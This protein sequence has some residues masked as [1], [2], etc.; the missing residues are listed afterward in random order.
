MVSL[1]IP[2]ATCAYS[3]STGQGASDKIRKVAVLI[4]SARIP[5]NGAGIGAWLKPVISDSLA[6]V[7]HTVEVLSPTTPPLP[8]GPIVDGT[9]LPAGI[10]DPALYPS[11]TIRKW[12]AY[13]SSTDLLV[14]LTPEYNS[15][16]PGE[17]KNALDH[18]YWEWRDKPAIIASYGSAGGPRAAEMLR[19]IVG[20][21]LRMRLTEKSLEIKLPKEYTG[22]AQKVPL[23]APFPEFLDSY[24]T[25]V[26]E[27]IDEVKK[28]WA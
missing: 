11:E 22:G 27:A 8:V 2:R 6:S 28:W 16:F 13:V 1:A 7:P 26:H 18:R 25:D 4:A 10:K 17:L 15:G 9:Y 23:V 5:C 3:T 21:S 12:S 19:G 24:Q 14:F 20:N